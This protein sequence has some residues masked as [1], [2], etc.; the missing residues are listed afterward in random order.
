MSGYHSMNA[1]ASHV[2]PNI[3][4]LLNGEPLKVGWCRLTLST[5]MLNAILASA[6]EA[7][8]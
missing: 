2:G 4:K 7:A 3:V 8:M 6:L 5:P 1:A